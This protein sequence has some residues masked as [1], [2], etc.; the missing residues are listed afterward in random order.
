MN[1]ANDWVGKVRDYPLTGVPLYLLVD[2]RQKT[3]TPFSRPDGTKYHR[4]EDIRRDPAHP[5]AVR[6]R[7]GHG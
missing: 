6:L 3:V 2:A 7:P 5:R 4:R 1:P